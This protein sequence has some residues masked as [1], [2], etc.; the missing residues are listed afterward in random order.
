MQHK[1][2]VDMDVVVMVGDMLRGMSLGSSGDPAI[3]MWIMA[4]CVC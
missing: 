4:G 3:H 2:E 1:G